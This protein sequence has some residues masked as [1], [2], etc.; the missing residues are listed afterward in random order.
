MIFLFPRINHQ[1]GRLITATILGVSPETH[2]INYKFL[3]GDQEF[4]GSDVISGNWG[5]WSIGDKI[6]IVYERKGPARNCISDNVGSITKTVLTI[7]LGLISLLGGNHG[8]KH[9]PVAQLD[10]SDF[11]C[12]SSG[13]NHR[14]DPSVIDDT[15]A[16]LC[17]VELAGIG[18]I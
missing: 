11:E 7:E 3:V 4:E 6:S 16:F 5:N 15:R 13:I 12:K 9:A 14:R 8:E 18:W 17:K 1:P 10:V 2:E